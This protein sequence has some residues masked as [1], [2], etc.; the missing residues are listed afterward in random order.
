MVEEQFAEIV[1]AL[2]RIITALERVADAQ[3]YDNKLHYVHLLL[4]ADKVEVD[5]LLAQHTR[6][7]TP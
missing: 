1:N 5:T 4:G 2:D 3:D 6:E 7:T